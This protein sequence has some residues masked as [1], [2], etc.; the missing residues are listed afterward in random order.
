MVTG[1]E[2][3]RDLDPSL[4]HFPDTRLSR[5]IF[6]IPCPVHI[7]CICYKIPFCNKRNTMLALVRLSYSHVTSPLVTPIHRKACYFTTLNGCAYI[8]DR[9]PRPGR[10]GSSRLLRTPSS[11]WS[12]TGGQQHDDAYYD[13]EFDHEFDGDDATQDL[14]Y[15]QTN[16]DRESYHGKARRERLGNL[17]QGRRR[18]FNSTN[19]ETNRDWRW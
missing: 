18:G 4:C 1:T 12:A 11:S 17:P 15:R 6:P 16:R 13:A 19:L 7:R 9:R 2:L 3:D 5:S 14:R 8:P 10:K